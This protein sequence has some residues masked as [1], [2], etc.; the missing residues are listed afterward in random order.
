MPGAGITEMTVIIVIAVTLWGIPVAA[1]IW[2]IITLQRIHSGQKII[3][4][5]LDEI[6]RDIRN[7]LP[8]PK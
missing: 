5:R 2:A 4:N 6:E 7:S 1:G 8:Q 3:R